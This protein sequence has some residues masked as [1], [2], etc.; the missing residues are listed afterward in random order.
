M[1]QR[2]VL[3]VNKLSLS[4]NWSITRSP[5]FVPDCLQRALLSR[6]L[7]QCL[8]V[9][10][11]ETGNRKREQRLDN[12]C[13]AQISLLRSLTHVE[14]GAEL[15]KHHELANFNAKNAFEPCPSFGL[16]LDALYSWLLKCLLILK[17]RETAECVEPSNSAP[18]CQKHLFP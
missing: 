12:A 18:K 17:F 11:K 16:S 4:R 13:C 6:S 1:V 7:S 3:V 9:N 2:F 10:C 5:R 15:R 14:L 8:D